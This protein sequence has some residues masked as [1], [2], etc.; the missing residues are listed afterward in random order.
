MPA[1]CTPAMPLLAALSTLTTGTS[2]PAGR[3]SGQRPLPLPAATLPPRRRVAHRRARCQPPRALLPASADLLLAALSTLPG[4]TGLETFEPQM[5][6][7]AVA[8]AA[9]A[10]AAPPIIFWLRIFFSAQRRQQA[11][12]A[13]KAA[14]QERQRQRD[15]RPRGM[16]F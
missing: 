7:P 14:E 16:Q 1:A 11:I 15:V 2:S 5:P 10:A 8:V 9:A 3:L 6:G 4:D 12:D 13:E